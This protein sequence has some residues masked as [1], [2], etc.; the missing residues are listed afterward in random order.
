MK[1]GDLK[2]QF[3]ASTVTDKYIQTIHLVDYV[4]WLEDRILSTQSDKS[5]VGEKLYREVKCSDRLPVICDE[6]YATD[7]G[8]LFFDFGT[9][10]TTDADDK[11]SSYEYAPEWW[12]EE[13]TPSEP[14]D[15]EDLTLNP[16]TAPVLKF[17]D[18]EYRDKIEEILNERYPAFGAR[19]RRV[20][21][22]I[23]ALYDGKEGRG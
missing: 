11:D 1:R 17:A 20:T 16:G 5:Q 23:L 8:Q 7:C 10:Y 4:K 22:A 15:N 13:L 2:K 18:K 6:W 3:A 14:T 12:L 19:N 9:W 21:D